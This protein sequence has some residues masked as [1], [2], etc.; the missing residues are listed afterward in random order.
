MPSKFFGA[1]AALD[2]GLYEAALR[3]AAWALSLI[4]VAK[5]VMGLLTDAVAVSWRGTLT[6]RLHRGYLRHCALYQLATLHP[7]IDNPDR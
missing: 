1:L 7:D 6:R 2:N 3:N 5:T 4:V